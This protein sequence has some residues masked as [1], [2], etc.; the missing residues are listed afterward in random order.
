MKYKFGFDYIPSYNAYRYT[1]EEDDLLR[2][3]YS[4]MSNC[5]ISDKILT[6]RSKSSIHHRLNR[7]GL[8]RGHKIG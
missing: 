4:S 2:Q 8:S 5:E 1:K 6:N 7:L 3:H